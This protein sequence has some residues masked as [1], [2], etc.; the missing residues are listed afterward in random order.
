MAYLMDLLLL[1][2]EGFDL[3]VQGLQLGGGALVILSQGH[4]LLQLVLQP[5][6]V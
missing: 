5:I 6:R 1:L 3:L 2:P 4:C